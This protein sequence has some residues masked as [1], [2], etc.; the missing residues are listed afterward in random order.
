MPFGVQVSSPGLQL[1]L[2]RVIL[3]SG[4]DYEAKEREAL[5]A[6]S[7]EISTS[8]AISGSTTTGRGGIFG[9]DMPALLRRNVCLDRHGQEQWSPR[10]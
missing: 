9:D 4:D 7:R 6:E 2:P 10:F 1:S 5:Q 3:F 8:R